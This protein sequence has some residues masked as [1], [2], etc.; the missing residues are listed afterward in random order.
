MRALIDQPWRLLCLLVVLTGVWG[1]QSGGESGQQEIGGGTG[2]TEIR[3]VGGR[4]GQQAP[5]F[6]LKRLAGGVLNLHQLRGKV[7]LL[8]FWDTWCGP[9]RIALP[10][11][12]ALST[13]YPGD[14][15]VV[16]VAMAQEGE[17]KVRQYVTSQKLTF[18]MVLYSQESSIVQDLGGMRG[19]PTTYLIGADGVI[20]NKWVGAKPKATYEKAVLA[21]IAAE[22]AS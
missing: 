9:C 3:D 8:D 20:I 7:V 18:E 4:P 15:V 14:L 6:E 21:A 5:D 16:G 1:C 17:Q 2:E 11:L 10:H 22:K 12:Q 19:I 13:E